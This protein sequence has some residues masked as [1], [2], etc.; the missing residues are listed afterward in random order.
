MVKLQEAVSL[1]LNAMVY[2]TA[3]PGKHVSARKIADDLGLTGWVKNLPDGKVEVMVEGEDEKI[4]TFIKWCKKGPRFSEVTDVDVEY[5]EHQG[6]FG[7]FK[8]K[9]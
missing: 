7:D 8:I 1:A 6:E 4:D 2:L 3:Y 9:H 5:E